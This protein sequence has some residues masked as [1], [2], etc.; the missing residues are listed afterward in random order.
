MGD[1]AFADFKNVL[2]ELEY[3]GIS[4]MEIIT[5]NPDF[6][7]IEGRKKLVEMGWVGSL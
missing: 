4:M 5:Q 3:K 7:F 6:H 1:V 2:D